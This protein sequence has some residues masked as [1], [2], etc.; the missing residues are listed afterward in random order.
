MDFA[1]VTQLRAR[2]QDAIK[3]AEIY[4]DAAET[5]PRLKDFYHALAF[6]YERS[7]REMRLMLDTVER[8][9]CVREVAA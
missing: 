9:S 2:Y 5:T 1:A 3:A 8:I 6:T 4:R 7:A